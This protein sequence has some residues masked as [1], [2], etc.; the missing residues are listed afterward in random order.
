MV[1][2]FD[3]GCDGCKVLV[4]SVR[5]EGSRRGVRCV[6]GGSVK[7]GGKGRQV[8]LRLETRDPKRTVPPNAIILELLLIQRGE[9]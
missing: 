6:S 1:G 7:S 4:C 3:L 2:R 9:R 5:Q 8:D